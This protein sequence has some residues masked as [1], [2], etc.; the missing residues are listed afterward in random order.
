MLYS[1]T[2]IQQPNH[3]CERP[4][5]VT[6][7][8]TSCIYLISRRMLRTATAKAKADAT[9]PQRLAIKANHKIACPP[10]SIQQSSKN[11][12]Y[13]IGSCFKRAA[14]SMQSTTKHVSFAR[15]HTVRVYN[16]TNEPAV[17]AT[18]DSGADGHYISEVDR[19]RAQLPILRP[20]SKRV[21][22]ANGG[23]STAKHV[24]ALPLPRLSPR[25]T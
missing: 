4:S 15:T 19:K 7:P 6:I 12:G 1:T 22:V 21:G 11:L 2:S 3:L 9:L 18:L 23:C 25:A 8:N 17:L 5:A 20:S 13:A 10:V 16:T 24:T 14:Q